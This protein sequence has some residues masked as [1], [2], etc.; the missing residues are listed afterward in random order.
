MQPN[1]IKASKV[2]LGDAATRLLAWCKSGDLPHIDAGQIAPSSLGTGL[3]IS[4]GTLVFD[5]SI[6]VKEVNAHQSADPLYG[7][8]YLLNDGVTKTLYFKYPGD[9]N[10][11]TFFGRVI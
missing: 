2:L 8:I 4:G 10:P 3:K 5:G 11:E 7:I 9:D 6:I 1:L